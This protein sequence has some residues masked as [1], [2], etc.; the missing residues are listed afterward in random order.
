MVKQIFSW[1]DDD[2]ML[3]KQVLSTTVLAYRPL[4]LKELASV[5]VITEDFSND[6]KT[7]REIVG[8]CGSLLILR[9]DIV[10]FVHQSAKDY[11]L[12]QAFDQ[13]FPSRKE[14]VHYVI[15]SRSLQVMS[16]TL[17]RDI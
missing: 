3:C 8:L 4:T 16:R 9:E 12:T 15:F 10:Y 11:L 1:D 7:L 17:Q 13:I 14:E 6:L 2:A 5:A